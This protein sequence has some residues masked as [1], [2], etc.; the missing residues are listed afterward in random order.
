MVGIAAVNSPDT[1]VVSGTTTAVDALIDHFHTRGR[2]TRRLQVSHAFHSPLMDPALEGIR[3][4]AA[5]ITAHPAT[6]PVISNLTA[7]PLTPDQ[8]GDGDYW[9]AHARNTVRFA[10]TLTRL[11]TAGAAVFVELGPGGALSTHGPACV[12]EDPDTVFLTAQRPDRPETQTLVEAVAT[13]HTRGMRLDW[14]AVFAGTGARITDLPT[15]A[16]DHHHYWLK[17]TNGRE[18]GSGPSAAADDGFWAALAAEEPEALAARLKVDADALGSVLP[19]LSS[20]RDQERERSAADGWRYRLVWRAAD[21]AVPDE[22]PASGTAAGSVWLVAVPAPAA[23]ATVRGAEQVRAIVDGLADR[24]VALRTVAVGGED[25]ATLA[26]A[27]AAAARGGADGPEVAGVLCLLPLDTEPHA[28]HTTLSR[29]MAATVTLVQALADAQV[30]APL[31]VATSGAVTLGDGSGNGNSAAAGAEH[32]DL[33]EHPGDTADTDPFQAAVWGLGAVLALDQPDTWGGLVD[34]PAEPSA[35]DV[36]LL[37]GAIAAGG[38]ED[39]VAIRSGTAHVRRMVRSPASAAGAAAAGG[40]ATAA[41]VW[42]PHGT[43][44]VTGGTGGVGANVAR[45]LAEEGADR[46]VLVSRRGADAPGAERLREE[47]Q[48]AGAAV[49]IAACDVTDT[50]EVRLLLASLSDGPPLTA[51]MHAAGTGHED[52]LVPQTSLDDFAGFGRAKVAGAIALD[53]VVDSA[54]R[55]AGGGPL[56]AF[57]LFSSGAAVWGS[58]GQAP[59][60]AANAFLDG[61]A[62]RRRARGLAASSIAWGGWGGGGMMEGTVQERLGRIGMRPMAPE[63]A[64]RCIGRS[65]GIGES[66]LVVTDVD[67]QRFA[68]AFT[69]AR[70][71][72][73]L[74]AVP[75]FARALEEADTGSGGDAAGSGGGGAAFAQRLAGLPPAERERA[76]VALVRSEAA[77]VLGHSAA[78][79]V[80]PDRAFNELGF[81]SLTAVEL[82]N[83]LREA[84]GLKLPATLVFDH[85]TS[86]ALARLLLERLAPADDGSPAGILDRLDELER[87]L[88]EQELSAGERARIGDRFRAVQLAA[89]A[90]TGEEDDGADVDALSDEELF[91][92]LDD[93]L[94][95]A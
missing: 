12:G 40:A 19:A 7:T 60:A 83:R 64:A 35:A 22:A 67:W 16:F 49:E 85:P 95:S 69:L 72:P 77:A 53:S 29:G 68:Q 59:Y 4:A 74:E 21:I 61:L 50:A 2:R 14:D 84:T 8:A 1:T 63:A 24:G 5:P 73:L 94:G 89:E 71:R 37:H 31:W 81:D 27:V 28:E 45:W 46:I 33:P 48:E 32:P 30:T 56:E 26:A 39:R 20:L 34:V 58:S 15:Y 43:V 86:L 42:R 38:G 18:S 78:D 82:R 25:R 79:A 10:D 91:A 23:P 57:V 66:H 11:H 41:P 13:A 17:P 80:E 88:R 6:I 9:A 70:R 3:Q 76:A 75:E 87:L 92:T 36:A 55:H 62:A 51:V 90:G 52:V 44:L 54:V 65:L 47:L 93:Q